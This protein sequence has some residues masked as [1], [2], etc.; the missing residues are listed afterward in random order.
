MPTNIGVHKPPYSSPNPEQHREQTARY[1][2]ECLHKSGI[3]AANVLALEPFTPAQLTTSANDY[4]PGPFTILRISASTPVNITGVVGGFR[5]RVLLFFNVGSN[6]I[7]LTNQDASSV[8]EN[9]IITK[10]GG[11]VSIG[12][13]GQAAMWYDDVSQRWRG[14]A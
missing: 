1:V 14:W 7:T 5:G 4:D 13:N 3:T 11:G 6:N 2:R 8:A 10:T 9:R 12:A